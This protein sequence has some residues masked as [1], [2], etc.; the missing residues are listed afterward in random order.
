MLADVTRVCGWRCLAWCLLSNHYHLLVQEGAKPIS[1]GMH[2]LQSRYARAFNE[3][4]ARSGHVFGERYRV[5]TIEDDAHL[6][7]RLVREAVRKALVRDPVQVPRL[8][9]EHDDRVA[10]GAAWV[11]RVAVDHLRQLVADARCEPDARYA[12]LGETVGLLH[13]ADVMARRVADHGDGMASDL[14][15]LFRY[16]VLDARLRGPVERAP[17]APDAEAPD[18]QPDRAEH[19]HRA[20]QPREAAPPPPRD[21]R[22]PPELGIVLVGRLVLSVPAELAQVGALR[23]A[24]ALRLLGRGHQAADEELQ[25]EPEREHE[26][27]P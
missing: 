10:G 14:L 3:R 17:A 26:W 7:P 18:D 11:L 24:T 8:V 5:A 13:R 23:S 19:E 9:C 12:D 27:Q 15:S 25:L 21:W 20:E 6:H 2:L 16:R 1:S 4:H 22:R